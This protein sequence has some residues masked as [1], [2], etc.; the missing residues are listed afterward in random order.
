MNTKTIET[1]DRVSETTRVYLPIG[2]VLTVCISIFY[3]GWA[4][5]S[6]STQLNL[7][8][9][10]LEELVT[11]TNDNDFS[12]VHMKLFCR[13]FNEQNKGVGVSCP[14]I[15]EIVDDLSKL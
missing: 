9:G 7:R 1:I 5:S 2:L 3:G 10:R 15:D 6:M 11:A 4:L 12:I 14:S 13:R 8:L